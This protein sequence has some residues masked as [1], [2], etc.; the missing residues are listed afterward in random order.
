MGVRIVIAPKRAGPP[1]AQ[2]DG[3]AAIRTFLM[4]DGTA[5]DALNFYTSL[6]PD[7]DVVSIDRYGE[8]EHGTE[9]TVKSAVFALNGQS[10]I[11]ID[12]P[13]RSEVSFTPA[14]AIFVDCGSEAEIETLFKKLSEDGQI[15]MP[16]NTYPFSQ[17]FGWVA[18]RYGVYWQLNLP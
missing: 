7:S 12:S 2:D 17:R 8:G 1:M 18:D 13:A 9:G 11:F 14:M 15:L 5:E 6:F 3:R 16:L 4:F 10:F